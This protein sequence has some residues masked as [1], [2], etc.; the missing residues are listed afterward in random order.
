MIKIFFDNRVF[1]L[2]DEP[3]ECPGAVHKL[4]KQITKTAEILAIFDHF[5]QSPQ[6]PEMYVLCPSSDNALRAIISANK[7]LRAAGGL[8]RD[9]SGRILLIR[10]LGFWDL[11]K[12][13]AEKGESESE[14]AIREVQEECGLNDLCL[15]EKLA[16]SYHVYKLNGERVLKETA[17]YAMSYSGSQ[18]PIPQ[19]EEDIEQIEWV[20][21]EN[22]KKYTKMY[23]SIRDFLGTF[24]LLDF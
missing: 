16:N 23:D 6:I 8:V 22:L 10:R 13:K 5:G 19:T 2:C 21:P 4:V 11:P 1:A 9:P 20:A 17:W 7:F 12:G 3:R 18:T 24:R 15:C 14:T